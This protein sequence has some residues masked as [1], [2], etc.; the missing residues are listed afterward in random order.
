MTK[1]VINTDPEFLKRTLVG[2]KP[3]PDNAKSSSWMKQHRPSVAWLLAI[4]SG[5][6]N[7]KRRQ[8]VQA[9]AIEMLGTRDLS[10]L[11]NAEILEIAPLEWQR[12]YLR[13]AIAYARYYVN[14]ERF[15]ALQRGRQ[16]KRD[17]RILDVARINGLA[18]GECAF[19]ISFSNVDQYIDQCPKVVLMYVRDYLNHDCFPIDRHV[20]RWLRLNHLPVNHGKLMS[21][22]RQA[23]IT[24]R[25]YARAIFGAHAENPVHA[26]TK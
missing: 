26:P 10:E 11:T 1:L 18:H 2:Y 16:S 20:R 8:S 22:F 4:L 6:W 5:P 23:K 12:S 17:V 9:H 19:G 15:D 25:G 14:N 13:A 3:I 24:A 7:I 21:I